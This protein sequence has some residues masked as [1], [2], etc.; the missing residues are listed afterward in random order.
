MSADQ[1]QHALRCKHG[2]LSEGG[3]AYQNGARCPTVGGAK[4]H[5]DLVTRDQT[6]GEP[7]V[8]ESVVDSAN[9]SCGS[10]NTALKRREQTC[11]RR[12]TGLWPSVTD[13]HGEEVQG[14]SYPRLH[15][16][17][18]P[19][20]SGESKGLTKSS[21]RDRSSPGNQSG[22]QLMA[23]V[24]G[25]GKASPRVWARASH[26]S[27]HAH[28]RFMP[29]PPTPPQHLPLVHH[30][31]TQL[32]FSLPCHASPRARTINQPLNTDHNSDITTV[33][34]YAA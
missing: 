6:Y 15:A 13:T 16:H 24:T 4:W 11:G 27:Q 34:A 21:V 25:P 1:G 18:T 17:G 30:T 12:R 32:N 8:D 31:P 19:R 2:M 5:V 33:L 29:A 23:A 10:D 3:P 22:N 20:Y 14:N 7:F 9:P 26:R 28:W